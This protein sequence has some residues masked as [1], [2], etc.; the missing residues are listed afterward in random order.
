MPCTGAI[1]H[2]ARP[3]LSPHYERPSGWLL[4]GCALGRTVTRDK[5]RTWVR[6][7][8]LRNMLERTRQ[9]SDGH[10]RARDRSGGRH[11]PCRP[12]LRT[13]CRPI[14]NNV[15]DKQRTFRRSVAQHERGTL[16]AHGLGRQ[17]GA[18]M[19]DLPH[20]GFIGTGNMGR[21]MARHLI[22][23]GYPLTV[24]DARR[25]AT[26]PLIELGALWAD[27]PADVA[28]ASE[29]VFTSLPGPAEVD[30]VALGEAGILANLDPDK[31]YIDLSTNAPSSIRKIHAAG[32]E[33]GVNVLDAPVSVG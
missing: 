27:S 23:A 5:Q 32:T 20:L 24:H 33:R 10:T 19:T 3:P 8:L 18:S 31:V 1:A 9:P 26:G 15:W 25:G 22:E 14:R 4:G 13:Q 28:Q 30:A 2:L 21:H 7:M 16:S 29:V 6:I 17:K 12:S 11:H